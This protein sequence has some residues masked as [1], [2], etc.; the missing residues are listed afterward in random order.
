MTAWNIPKASCIMIN[1]QPSYTLTQSL[2]RLTDCPLTHPKKKLKKMFQKCK[3]DLLICFYRILWNFSLL[4]TE[5][6]SRR[7]TFPRTQNVFTILSST[8]IFKIKTVDVVTVMGGVKYEIEI[9]D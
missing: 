9:V 4:L 3:R 7:E 5:S 2:T 6:E 1:S 8:N